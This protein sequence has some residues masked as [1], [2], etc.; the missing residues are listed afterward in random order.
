[1]VKFIKYWWDAIPHHNDYRYF[2]VVTFPLLLLIAV[3][4]TVPLA[5]IYFY[6]PSN[7]YQE[8]MQSFPNIFK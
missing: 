5:G 4:M 8:A 7:P 2:S 6:N 1:M 3:L